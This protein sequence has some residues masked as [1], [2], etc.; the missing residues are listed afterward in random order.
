MLALVACS[1]SEPPAHVTI[2]AIP[3]IAPNAAP[4]ATISNTN[5]DDTLDNRAVLAVCE[6]YR[7]AMESRDVDAVLA[8]TSRRYHDGSVTYE[9]LPTLLK[10]V[11]ANVIAVRYELRYEKVSRTVNEVFVDVQSSSSVEMT[12]GGWTHRIDTSRLVLVREDGEYR[13]IRGM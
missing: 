8:V 11:M 3:P 10:R 9:T 2:E 4:S 5:V 12:S 1:S 6:R 7:V 13:I